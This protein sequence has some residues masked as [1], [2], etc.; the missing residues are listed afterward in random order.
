MAARRKP[1]HPTREAWL[2]AL[3]E[4]LR[5]WFSELDVTVPPVRIGVGFT[6]KGAR[7]NRIGECW[8]PTASSDGVVEVFMHPKLATPEEVG[9]VLVHELIHAGVGTEAKHG[10]H[11][12]RPALALGLTGRMTATV[13]TPELM[14]R[15]VPVFKALGPYPH[16]AFTPGGG[17]STGPKQTTRM[18]KVECP[19][20]GYLV[21]TTQK[22]L[23]EA[24]PECPLGHGEMVVKS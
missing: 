4:E 14:K 9:P 12:K 17:S 24:I 13:A 18:L 15:L 6:S 8:S 16:G 21:R 11:F 19:S 7:S 2:Q 23:D 5:P 10:P 20:C 3:A 1:I 22:W